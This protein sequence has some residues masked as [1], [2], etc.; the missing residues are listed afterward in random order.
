MLTLLLG[1]CLPVGSASA[2]P[3]ANAP[4]NGTPNS[5]A[6]AP[7]ITP[8]PVTPPT[9]PGSNLPAFAC[10]NTGGGSTGAAHVTM[11]RVGETADFDR[12]VLQFDGK[13]P[14][15]TVKRQPKPTF[16][17]GGSG[18]TI[19]L[20]GTVGVLVSVSSAT[21]ATTFSGPTDLVHPEYLVLKEARQTQDFEGVVSWGLGLAYAACLRT[22]TLSNPAR[23]V[24][25]FRTKSP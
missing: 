24:V 1:A 18:Q 4:G 9:P 7:R 3:A 22:F 13:V 17:M 25:D 8:P 16:T 12:F 6:S 14:T 21:G 2:T 5:A 20:S 15:Y 23:L 11:A 19:T 10:A